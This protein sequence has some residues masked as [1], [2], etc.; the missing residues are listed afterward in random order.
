MNKPSS[1]IG[2][3]DDDLEIVRRCCL[4]LATKLGSLSND[5]VVVGGL[6]PSLLSDHLSPCGVSES[7]SP[8]TMISGTKDLDLGLALSILEE[9]KYTELSDLLKRA[10]FV[11]DQ[12]SDG[13]QTRQRWRITDPYFVTVEFLIQPSKEDD[14][15]GSLRDIEQDFAAFII[16]GLHLAFAD[17]RKIP[18][19]GYTLF[20][21]W[22]EREVWVC[23]P[24]AFLVLKALALDGRGENKDAYDLCHMINSTLFDE[25]S[26]RGVL[27]FFAANRDDP[28][29]RRAL[30]IIERDFARRDGVGPMRTAEFLGP[31]ADENVVS[32]AFGLAQRLLELVDELM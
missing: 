1:Y 20:N 22:A 27:A 9:K 25:L 17:R 10:G 28:E 13:K 30:S 12:N 15:G 32:D 19:E 31:D 7:D 29:V 6:V 4:Y 26:L 21:E 24:G 3:S 2:Y 11:P 8:L 16:P 5:I 18:I 14:V 23:G